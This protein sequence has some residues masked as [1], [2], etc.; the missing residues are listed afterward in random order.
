MMHRAWSSIVEVPYCFARSYV[1]FQG[2]TALKIVE[3][4]PNWAFPDSNSSLNSPMA[5]KC[6]TKLETAKDRCPIV[7][8]GHP[9]NFKVT[10]DKTSPILTQIGRFR[11]IGRSQLSNPSDLPCFNFKVKDKVTGKTVIFS[12]DQAALWMVQSVC[13]SVCP[14][15][16]L[17]VRLSHLFDYVPII[18]SS[19]NFQ[20]LLPVTKVTSMQ[21]VKVRGQ[22]SR[23][24]RSQPNLTVSGL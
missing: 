14:S 1:K 5:M 6:C 24:Q 21:K 12:C 10:R 7:F 22:R 11:T 13:P 4:D 8:Q 18:L 2:H 3:F 19:W 23:S 9:S 16:R 20:E 15:V 17:S